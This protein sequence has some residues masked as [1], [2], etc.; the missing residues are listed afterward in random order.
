MCYY[1]D[2]EKKPLSFEDFVWQKA[3]LTYTSCWVTWDFY[4]FTQNKQW[5]MRWI[6]NQRM[7]IYSYLNVHV[8]VDWLHICFH[9][10]YV[11]ETLFLTIEALQIVLC[12]NFSTFHINNHSR[13]V[14]LFRIYLEQTWRYYF[15]WFLVLQYIIL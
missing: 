1:S 4:E 14:T 3:T 11:I 8:N 2:F 13:N 7:L 15:I 6:F 5:L 10:P 9:A 12:L